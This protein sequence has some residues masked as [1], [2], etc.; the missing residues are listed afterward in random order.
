[1]RGGPGSH[2]SW[3]W[4]PDWAEL[5]LLEAIWHYINGLCPFGC[6]AA[7]NVLPNLPMIANPFAPLMLSTT[8]VQGGA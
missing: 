3:L 4:A 7:G 1:M 8:N 5:C 2:T 6:F